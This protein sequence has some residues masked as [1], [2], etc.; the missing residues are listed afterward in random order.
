MPKNTKSSATSG[1]RKKNARKAAVGV[2]PPEVPVVAKQKKQKG[3]KKEPRKKV[4]IP[5]FKP[6]PP[7]PDPLDTLGLIHRLPPEL[8]IILRSLGKKDPVTKGRALEEL[9]SQWIDESSRKGDESVEC[10]ALV[11]M[12]PVWVCR[13]A[14]MIHILMLTVSSFIGLLYSSHI[15]S[16]GSASW[17]L[18]SIFHIYG[19]LLSGMPLSSF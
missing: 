17:L 19:S 11:T 7:Q 4:Y 14:I 15:L 6:A 9:Q 13:L 16:A 18:H 10:D 1:T 3:Q 5:P 12:L 8:V 2:P